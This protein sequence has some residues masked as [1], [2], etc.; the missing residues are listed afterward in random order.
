MRE[1]GEGGTEKRVMAVLAITNGRESKNVV[2][3]A[4]FDK[5]SSSFSFGSFYF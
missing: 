5:P 2:T 3:L 1:R 4:M